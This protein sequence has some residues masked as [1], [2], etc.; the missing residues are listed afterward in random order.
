VIS[1]R[2]TKIIKSTKPGKIA[3]GF[4]KSVFWLIK[5]GYL[6]SEF[7][8]SFGLTIAGGFWSWGKIAQYLGIAT[9]EEL[10]QMTSKDFKDRNL[11]PQTLDQMDLTNFMLE[12]FTKILQKNLVFSDAL[13]NTYYLDVLFLQLFLKK[14]GSDFITPFW[15]NPNSFGSSDKD[16]VN[17]TMGGIKQKEGNKIFIFINERPNKKSAIDIKGQEVEINGTPFNG[18]YKILDFYYKDGKVVGFYINTNYKPKKGIDLSF[19]NKGKIRVKSKIKGLLG[20]N[21]IFD[22]PKTKYQVKYNWGYYD[23]STVESVK[24]YQKKNNLPTTGFVDPKTLK[25]II[26]DL[27]SKKYGKITNTSGAKLGEKIQNK[28]YTTNT[29]IK[30]TPLQVDTVIVNQ[31]QAIRDSLRQNYDSMMVMPNTEVDLFI[32]TT[33]TWGG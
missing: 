13:K 9:S 5:N 1:N 16:I 17:Y 27:K 26:S 24:T 20:G 6:F 8:I 11:N 21:S 12:D 31:P 25:I 7:L 33:K 10:K 3:Y 18:K 22:Q 15:E 30:I 28:Q 2:L 14:S 19:K 32:D 4:L 23:K 29:D